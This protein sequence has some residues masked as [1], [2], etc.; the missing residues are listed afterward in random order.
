LDSIHGGG[1]CLTRVRNNA[2]RESRETVIDDSELGRALSQASTIDN[3]YFR[4]RA[5]AV[6]SLLRLSGKRRTEIAWIPLENFKVENDLLTVTFTLEKKKRKHKKCPA[7]TTKNSS[8]SSFCKKCG[9]RI[10]EV[11]VT[12]TSKQAKSVKAFPLSDPLTK[13]LLKYLD[14]LTSLNPIPK[15]WLPSGRSV[16]GNYF[17]IPDKHLSDREVFNIVR[18]ASETLWPHLF[19]ETVASDIV[20]QDNS[21]IAAFKVQKRLDLEDM[22]TGF[23]YLQRFA[24]D[25]IKR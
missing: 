19:R 1:V 22:R 13:N 12:F 9:L 8:P 2:F 24:K 25:I 7:C 10:S 4:L 5:V 20:R 23:N 21:I 16:F 14:Y 17:I 18:G 6:L 15:F 11:P 3:E